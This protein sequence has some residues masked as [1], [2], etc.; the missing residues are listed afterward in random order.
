MATKVASEALSTAAERVAVSKPPFRVGGKKLYLPNHVITFLRPKP[1][2]SSTTATFEVPLTF[3][4]LDLR[5]YLYHLYNVEVTSIRSLINQKMP[6][7]RTVPGKQSGQWYRPQSSKLMIV[8]LVKPFVW[9]ERPA[10]EDMTPWDH[11]LFVAVEKGHSKDVEQ[12]EAM[13]SYGP[14]KMRT[15]QPP[16][17]ER[18]ALRNMAS[19]LLA[20]KQ[21]WTP[22]P[23]GYV[24]NETK[25]SGRSTAGENEEALATVKRSE[26]VE[27]AQAETTQA[28]EADVKAVSE[29]AKEKAKKPVAENFSHGQKL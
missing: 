2:Q 9:P 6:T 7:Q 26:K 23:R 22:G 21:Q 16:T 4:K 1:G 12:A 29:R 25:D 17:R 27:A 10:E 15:D 11:K 13:G 8:D 20:G 5:D 19:Q 3:N 14:R 24:E 28:I 18:K